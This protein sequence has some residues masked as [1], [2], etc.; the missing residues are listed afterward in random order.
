[1]RRNVIN[2]EPN[3]VEPISSKPNNAEKFVFDLNRVLATI[4][5]ENEKFLQT[6]RNKD[7]RTRL[8]S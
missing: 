8:A 1:M 2:P 3:N 5:L 6:G 4:H 7:V